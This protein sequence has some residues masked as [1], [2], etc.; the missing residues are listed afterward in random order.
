MT[1]IYKLLKSSVNIKKTEMA[2][3]FYVVV[4]FYE[5]YKNFMF[6]DYAYTFIT[7]TGYETVINVWTITLGDF[8]LIVLA[9]G[10]LLYFIM[11]GKKLNIKRVLKEFMTN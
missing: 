11:D 3:M 8:F 10:Y 5:V 1:T 6:N 2:F 4:M 9:H 7:P